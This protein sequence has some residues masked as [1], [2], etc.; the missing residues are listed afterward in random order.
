M[1]EKQEVEM[2]PVF[3]NVDSSY[4]HR[5]ALSGFLFNLSSS[6]VLYGHRD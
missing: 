4:G 2:L 3:F 5:G 6:N 1:I